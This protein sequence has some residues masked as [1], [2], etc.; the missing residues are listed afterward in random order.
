MISSETR[1]KF[2]R[3]SDG[4]NKLSEKDRKTEAESWMAAALN[5]LD[6]SDGDIKKP[7]P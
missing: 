4:L 3:W 5:I 2:R 7:K 6:R 1:R